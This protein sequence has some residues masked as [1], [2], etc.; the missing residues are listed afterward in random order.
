MMRAPLFDKGVLCLVK[1]LQNIDN[2]NGPYS[3][4]K[5]SG[6]NWSAPFVNAEKCLLWNKVVSIQ[7]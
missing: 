7:P 5:T 3:S 4:I 2:L 6:V 1:L